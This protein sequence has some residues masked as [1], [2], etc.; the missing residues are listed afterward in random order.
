MAE[1][2]EEQKIFHDPIMVILG[3]KEYEIKP[4][5]IKDSRIF[6]QKVWDIM[7]ELPKVT[8]VQSDEGDKF[9]AALKSML[10]SMPDQIVDLFFLYARELPREDIEA[11]ATDSEM[12]VAWQQ[13]MSIAFPLLPGLVTSM[14]RMAPPAAQSQ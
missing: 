13:V 6:R 4:L 8:G 1:R 10:V 2:T 11:I 12:A 5:P 14:G 3:G 7:I 9:E